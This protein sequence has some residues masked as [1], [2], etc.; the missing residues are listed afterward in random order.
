MPHTPAPWIPRMH[1]DTL[2]SSESLFFVEEGS[3]A[4]QTHPQ[5][6]LTI[7]KINVRAHAPHLDEP[8]ANTLLIAAAPVMFSALCD[9]SLI[10]ADTTSSAAEKVRA[11]ARCARRALEKARP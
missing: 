2:D 6:P 9:I 8:K 10:E 5:G 7:A 1:V 11:M 4:S 3:E